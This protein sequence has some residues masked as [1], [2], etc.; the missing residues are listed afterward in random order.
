MQHARTGLWRVEYRTDMTRSGSPILPLAFLV[1]ADWESGARWLGMLF[2]RSLTANELKAVD[3]ATWPELEG[4]E[5]FLKGMFDEAWSAPAGDGG[6]RLV[7]KYSS[8]S[9]VTLAPEKPS[10][11]LVQLTAAQF[12]QVFG[13]L[14][15]YLWNFKTQLQPALKADVVD[16]AKGKRRR[17]TPSETEVG[18]MVEM[19]LPQPVAA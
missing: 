15:Q 3:L 11:Q 10:D 17:R 12:P 18:E 7:S 13:S 5:P 4:P 9:A 1:E 14:T 2:R 8:R 6:L 16:F 19:G